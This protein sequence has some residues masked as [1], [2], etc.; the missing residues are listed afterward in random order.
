V[1]EPSTAGAERLVLLLAGLGHVVGAATEAVVADAELAV[2]SAVVVLCDVDLHG[3]RRPGQLMEAAGLSSGGMSKLLDRMEA[4]GVIRRSYGKV[5]G[6]NRG[7]LVTIT[8]RGRRTVRAVAAE[9]AARLPDAQ[10]LV[11]ELAALLEG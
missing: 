7:V 11:D 10:P 1:S 5:P 3:P 9:V 2:A 4:A 6:D 8:A